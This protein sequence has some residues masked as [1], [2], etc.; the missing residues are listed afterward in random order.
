[1]SGVKPILTSLEV[2][3]PNGEL[4]ARFVGYRGKATRQILFMDEFP[5]E[6]AQFDVVMMEGSIVSR[7]SVREAHRVLK[8]NGRL[9]FIVPE[10]TAKQD[11]WTASDVYAIVRDGFNILQVDRVSWWSFGR[12]PRT[13]TI[14]AGKKNW[15]EYK[16][17]IRNQKVVFPPFEKR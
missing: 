9:F 2:G 16:S 1:M 17:F 13:L 3:F 4:P 14:C 7:A 15:R 6:D 12:K 5:F 10:K 11:G 8:P